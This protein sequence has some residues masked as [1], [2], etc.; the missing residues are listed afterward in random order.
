MDVLG[1][2]VR[3]P[4]GRVRVGSGAFVGNN[5]Y[6]LTGSGQS[7]T[8]SSAPGGTITFGISIQNDGNGAEDFEVTAAG[9]ATSAYTVKY[10]RGT[11]D[12]TSTV[13]TGRYRTPSLEPG[14]TYLLTAKV[15]VKSIA[16]AGSSVTRLLTITSGASFS[17]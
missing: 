6:N 1:S 17:L 14:A 13:V 5:I 8:G 12:I 10:F 15:T 9:S 7:R 4:D 3:R 2:F 16:G 11:T